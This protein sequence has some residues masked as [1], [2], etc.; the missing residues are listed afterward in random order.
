MKFSVLIL[1]TLVGDGVLL[2]IYDYYDPSYVSSVIF[3]TGDLVSS[4][5]FLKSGFSAG[6]ILLYYFYG[7]RVFRQR[8]F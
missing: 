3:K 8:W 4:N 1:L 7:R 2:S 5:D 6:V